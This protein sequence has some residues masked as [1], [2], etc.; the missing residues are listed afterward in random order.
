MVVRNNYVWLPETS[1][2]GF[3]AN[4]EI[5]QVNRIIKYETRYDH[6][7]ARAEISLIDYPEEREL[8]VLLFVD[9]LNLETPSLNRE[10]MKTLFFAIEEDFLTEKN[11]QKRYELIVKNEYFNALQIKYAYS[12]TC[13]KAQGGE[14]PIVYIDHDYL[15]PE[16]I[17]GSFYKWLYT[18]FTRSKEKI[19]LINFDKSFF[20]IDI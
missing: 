11:K 14:W 6:R 15:L 16:M 4:G 20:L 5:I 7:F 3:I 17:D 18:A 1:K 10:T 19:I 2:A 8:E 13:H 12:I 9:T